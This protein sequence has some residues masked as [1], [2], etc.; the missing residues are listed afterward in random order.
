MAEN[1]RKARP[2]L[3]RAAVLVAASLLVTALS[4]IAAAEPTTQQKLDAA[5]AEV[6]RLFGEIADQ[7][8]YLAQLSQE[9]GALAAKVDVAQGRWEQITEQL[10]TTRGEL[11]T[12]REE[13]AR[14]RGQLDERAREAYM[15]GP[16]DNFEFLL[17]ATSLADLSDRVEF[18]DALSQTDT[19]LANQ[20]ENLRNDLSAQAADEQDLQAKAADALRKVQAESAALDAKLAEQQQVMD[21]LASKKARAEQLVKDL[22]KQYQKELEALM[23]LNIDPNGLLQTCPV[24]QPRAVYD[25]FG[26][27]RYAGGYHP[28]AG[29]DIIAPMGTAIRAPFPGTAHSSYNSLGG[30][31]VYVDGAN[32]YVYNAHLSAYSDH[33]N[34]PVQTGDI[35][36]Y[37]GATGDTSTPHDHFEW[38]P[39]VI[40]TNWPKSPYGYDVI[41]TAV[42]PWPLLQAVC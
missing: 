4:G 41:G 10:R 37:V 39:N 8:D 9:A 19:D 27:P 17:G 14:L 18:V 6:K 3:R 26:A 28:H 16:G 20:V 35:I 23:G 25:G 24:D 42:N 33:S 2:A 30:N 40:P 13:Y 29:N 36:G 5:K 22:T 31:A 34:G 1:D 12:A 15:N 38:H 7:Q 21:D 32:G 11:E